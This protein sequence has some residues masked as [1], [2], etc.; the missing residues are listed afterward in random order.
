[1][2]FL[3]DGC[4]TWADDDGADEDSSDVNEEG[5]GSKDLKSDEGDVV[6]YCWV[7]HVDWET[8]HGG[9]WARRS[10]HSRSPRDVM[11]FG[12]FVSSPPPWATVQVVL[13]L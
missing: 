7:G 4:Y 8:V 2:V 5:E 9:R 11:S 6:S 3:G 1:M 12:S 13:R 10:G